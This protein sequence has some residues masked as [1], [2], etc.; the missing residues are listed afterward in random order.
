MFKVC[1]GKWSGQGLKLND[2]LVEL[3]IYVVEFFLYYDTVTIYLLYPPWY[4][5]VNVGLLKLS[6]ELI[7]TV[8]VSR[9]SYLKV[10]MQDHNSN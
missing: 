4:D 10:N 7:S 1:V 6:S 9:E 8:Y 3:P 2:S 5:L